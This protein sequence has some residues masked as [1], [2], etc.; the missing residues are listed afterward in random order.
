MIRPETPSDVDA[1]RTVHDLAF[2]TADAGVAVK[3]R[4]LDALRTDPG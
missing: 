4:L 3:S 1:V 2:A